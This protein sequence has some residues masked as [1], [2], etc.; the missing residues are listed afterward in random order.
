MFPGWMTFQCCMSLIG[1]FSQKIGGWSWQR[2]VAVQWDI[3]DAPQRPW[4]C[5]YWKSG[6]VV[7]I[8]T[9]LNMRL[10]KSGFMWTHNGR[11][12]TSS[13]KVISYNYLWLL[14]WWR[15]NSIDPTAV[16]KGPKYCYQWCKGIEGKGFKKHKWTSH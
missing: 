1:L 9:H 8:Y 15:I 13:I 7:E 10:N 6:S 12:N 3:L 11:M 16:T 5:Q 2:G 4:L 14:A